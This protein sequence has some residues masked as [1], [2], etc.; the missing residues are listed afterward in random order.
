M[1][2]FTKYD[3]HLCICDSL[4]QLLELVVGLVVWNEM[5][6]S[7][8]SRDL[9]HVLEFNLLLW[10]NLFVTLPVWQYYDPVHRRPK[11]CAGEM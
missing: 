11:F 2:Q 5:L 3:A 7:A 6:S 10:S 9:G 8:R 1:E 4:F